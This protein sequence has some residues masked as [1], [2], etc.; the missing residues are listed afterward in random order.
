MGSDYDQAI[1]AIQWIA[2]SPNYPTR[3]ERIAQIGRGW[4]EAT[5]QLASNRKSILGRRVRA[6]SYRSRKGEQG[7]L[8]IRRETNRD[9]LGHDLAVTRGRPGIPGIDINQCAVLC[10]DSASCKAL[11]L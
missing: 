10:N 7:K 2:N 6:T 9:I 4:T 8:A 1:A 5:G 11:Q 3:D